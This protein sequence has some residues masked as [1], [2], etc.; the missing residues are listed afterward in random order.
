MSLLPLDTTTLSTVS[1]FLLIFFPGD[2]H[3]KL[4]ENDTRVEETKEEATEFWAAG[5]AYPERSNCKHHPDSNTL[6]HDQFKIQKE[7]YEAG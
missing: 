5:L 2:I 3:S 6:D 4:P 7:R 1:I